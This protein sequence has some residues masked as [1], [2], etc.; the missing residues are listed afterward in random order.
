MQTQR[1]QSLDVFRGA[2]VALMILVNNPGSWA[3]IFSPLEHASWH[4]LTPTDL[5]FP[6]FLFAV[7]NAMSFVM[8]KLAQ[9]TDANF[10]KK[11]LKRTLMIFAIGLFLNWSPFVKW[12]EGALVFKQWENVRIL[13]VLQRIA[14]CY[15]F[16]SVIIYYGK[17]K[18]ALYIGA[19]I[20]LLYWLLTTLLGAP[21]HPYS[22]S[23]YFGNAIDQSILGVTHIYKGEGVPFDPEGLTST[24]PAIVQVIFGFLVGEYIQN[25]G[26]NFEM[27]S[28]LL[29]TGVILVLAGYIWDFSFPINKKIWTSSYVVYTSGLAMITLSIFIY[30]IEFKNA[31]G[32]WSYFFE[33]FGKNPLFI[34]VLSGFLPRVLALLRW[35]DHV[36]ELG[37]KVYTSSLP[38][39]YEHICKKIYADLRIGSLLYAL[40]FIAVMASL[41]YVLD[42]KRIYIKV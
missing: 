19:V 39:F 26:K 1:Y 37:E 3:H 4:G 31:T 8:P 17:S 6:F 32:K 15:F 23:G 5:V 38:W 30:L 40:C 11:V 25:K 41:A 24:L 14:L 16:A 2:T 22:L 33:V 20:L 36:N 18:W 7:G 10:W 21:G 34:F 29:L 13:G 28:Q 42:K 9:G 12:S 27:L 35:E